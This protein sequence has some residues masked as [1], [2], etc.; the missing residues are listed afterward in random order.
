MKWREVV[1]DYLYFSRKDRIAV[2]CLVAVM[3]I[4]YALP[5]LLPNVGEG[6][7]PVTDTMLQT[8]LKGVPGAADN[9]AYADDDAPHYTDGFAAP[10]AARVRPGAPFYFD[11]NTLSAEGWQRLGLSARASKTI[12]NYRSKGGRFYKPEDLKKI[13]GLPPGF[14]ERVAG[15]IRV[16]Q[17]GQK[18]SPLTYKPEPG[19]RQEKRNM[20][21]ADVNAADTSALIALPGIGSKLASRIIAFR[22]RLGGFYT[23]SQVAETYGLADSV[24]QKIEP[25]LQ[26]DAAGI[27]KLNINTATNEELKLHPYIRWNLANAIVAYRAHHGDFKDLNDLK[28]IM[29]VDEQTFEKIRHYLQL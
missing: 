17:Q 1:R 7:L 28:K 6:A 10:Q 16:P 8:M 20:S 15:Y 14:Y 27:R 5:T 4:I 9:N 18:K 11:P 21:I 22:D 29:L 12:M 23:V 26:V 13:W 24:F 19:A 3:A 2:F 25:F